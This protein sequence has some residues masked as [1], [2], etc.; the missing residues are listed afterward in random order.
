MKIRTIIY[1]IVILTGILIFAFGLN[2]NERLEHTFATLCI[3]LG[4]LN[5]LIDL[6]KKLKKEKHEINKA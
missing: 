5:I 1:S 6:I 3:S 2:T 4:A